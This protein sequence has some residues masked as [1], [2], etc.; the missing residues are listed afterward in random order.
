MGKTTLWRYGA[1]VAE[2]LGYRVLACAPTSDEAQ[3]AFS[4]LSDLLAPVVEHVLGDLPGPQRR[5]LEIALLLRE[6]DGGPPDERAIAAAVASA[7]RL[8]AREHPV[9]VA[10]DDVQWLDGPSAHMLAY[11]LRR[12]GDGDRVVVLLARRV[13]NGVEATPVER[14]LPEE[15]LTRVPVGALSLGALSRLL[16]DRLD[17][18]LPRSVLLRVHDASGGNPFYALELARALE[19]RTIASHEPLPVPGTLLGLLEDRL[20]TLPA[21]TLAVLEAAALLAEPTTPRLALATRRSRRALEPAVAAGVI[22]LEG[23]RVRF[24]HPL[25]AAAI[26]AGMG[27]QDRARVH[28]RLA[29]TAPTLEERAYHLALGADRPDEGVAGAIQEAAGALV[30]RGAPR[31]AAEFL[32]DAVRLTP[33]GNA[34]GLRRRLLAAGR[35]WYQ[36]FDWER[37]RERARRVLDDAPPG[38]DLADALLLLVACHEDPGE[39]KE[40][41]L[42]EAR[43]DP[44][45]RA[46]AWTLLADHELN[47]D[48]ERSLDTARRAVSDAELAGDEV[49]LAHA[50]AALGVIETVLCVGTPREHLERGIEIERRVTG[51]DPASRRRR[52]S[53]S[54]PLRE[55]SSTS[56]GTSS[57]AASRSPRRPGTTPSA[58]TC[59]GSSR[60][61]S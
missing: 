32:D 16:R 22:E 54:T 26:V 28:R 19:G 23:E 58:R 21:G 47:V 1:E 52:P 57:S 40:L 3:L 6:S 61:S 49:L 20:G 25:L 18:P 10:C 5:A 55:T 45:L 46:R 59:C 41:I 2:D 33:T 7:L 51:I 43:D 17:E 27:V 53:P 39:L 42:D 14:A 50:L 38:A 13:E 35:A 15:L 48:A 60:T 56:L 11:A 30:A 8:S 36:A 44:A 9:L 4:V 34:A 31:L 29:T 24:A 37:A 12:L